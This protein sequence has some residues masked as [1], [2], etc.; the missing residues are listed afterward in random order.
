[1][2]K[3]IAANILRSL[4]NTVDAQYLRGSLKTPLFCEYAAIFHHK[5]FGIFMWSVDACGLSLDIAHIT[6]SALSYR[7][8]RQ[9][10][11]LGSIMPYN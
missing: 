10:R 8:G 1:M 11:V 2:L 5:I 4:L 7:I 3:K 6:S 9:S